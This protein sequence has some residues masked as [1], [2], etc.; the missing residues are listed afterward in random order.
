MY[1]F[2]RIINAQRIPASWGTA[3]TLIN[4][5]GAIMPSL[6]ISS[7]KTFVQAFCSK[8]RRLRWHK[9]YIINIEFRCI[10]VTVVN[11][12]ISCGICDARI[13][14]KSLVWSSSIGSGII[15][16]GACTI[17][18]RWIA[19][20]ITCLYNGGSLITSRICRWIT[21]TCCAIDTYSLICRSSSIGWVRCAC[22]RIIHR[23]CISSASCIL[24][25]ILWDDCRVWSAC[26]IIDCRCRRVTALIC[27]IWGAFSRCCCCCRRG[28]ICINRCCISCSFLCESQKA[29]ET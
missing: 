16:G 7:I 13:R 25:S 15:Y 1:S 21:R 20:N 17:I 4:S 14:C 11:R 2:L 24:C 10:I 26:R 8:D 28:G 18:T 22:W 27:C 5:N 3:Y 9:T 23:S 19:G 12:C 29:E 6:S